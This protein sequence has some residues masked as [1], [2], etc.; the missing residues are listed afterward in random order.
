MDNL[1]KSTFSLDDEEIVEEEVIDRDEEYDE[2]YDDEYDDE[3]YDDGEYDDE[4]YDDDEYADEEEYDDGYNDDYYDDR[5]NKVLDEIAELKRGMVP[6]TV[7]QQQPQQMPPPPPP[8]MPPQ[9]IY[10]PSV[11]SAGSE[12]VM[13][14]EISRLRDE[15][16]KN[17]SSLEMQKE[18]T[19]IKED[20]ARDQRFAEAQYNAEIQRLQGK[21]DELL[22]NADGPQSDSSVYDD[23][24]HL[25]GEKSLNL[26]KLLS[27][28]EV[29]LR[30]MRDSDA[31]IQSEIAQL[32]KQL[33]EIPSLKELNGAVSAVKKALSNAEGVDS[34]AMSKLAAD[35][36]ALKTTLDE[37]GGVA[38]SAAPAITTVVST[39][40][41][42][43][44]STS[45]LLRQ[46]YEIKNALGAS[47]EEAVKRTQVL[48]DLAGEYKKISLDV[49]SQTVQYK[50]KLSAAYGFAKKLAACGE[51]DAV[52][53]IVA[54][55]TI[56][57]KLG[58]QSLNR[59]TF[60]DVAAFCSEN[61][62]MS[63]TSAI[64]DSA[65]KYFGICE[66]LAKTPVSGYGEYIAD[67]VAQ[68]N[69]LEDN[70]RKAENSEIVSQIVG[71]VSAEKPDEAEVRKLLASLTELKVSDIIELPQVELPNDYTP[72]HASDADSIIAR[73]E[74]IHSAVLDS[75]SLAAANEQE[76]ES[77]DEP[78]E[79]AAEEQA[80]AEEPV[81]DN[82]LAQAIEELKAQLAEATSSS[83]MSAAIEEIRK[84]YIDVSEKLVDIS[85]DLKRANSTVVTTEEGSTVVSKSNGMTDEEINE[86]LDNLKYIRSK[87]DEYDEFIRHIDELKSD[88]EKHSTDITDAVAEQY[89]KIVNELSTQFDKLYDDISNVVLESESSI[90]G[91]IGDGLATAEALDAAKSDILADTHSI[92]DVLANTQPIADI[93]AN[94]QSIADVLSDTQ[95]ILSETQSIKDTLL[96]MTDSVSAG[97]SGGDN[98]EAVKAD[99]LAE[100]QSIKDTLVG[101]SDSVYALP[102]TENLEA[103][104]EE[105]LADTQSIKDTLVGISDSIF[106]LPL[107]ENLEATKADLLVETQSIKDTLF[108]LS[109]QLT[110]LQNM[111]VADAVEQ[112]RADVS[113][114]VEVTAMNDENATID[115][116]KLLDDIAFLRE[117]AEL[118][119]AS[120][121][122][123]PDGATAVQD[124]DKLVGYLD[125]IA[126]RVAQLNAIADDASA[127]RENVAA[128]GDNLAAVSDSVALATDTVAA[129]NDSIAAV[130]NGVNSANDGIVALTDTVN[131]VNDS[132]AALTDTFNAGQDNLAAVVDSVN[133]ASDGIAAIGDT[134]NAVNDSVAV[135]TDTFNAD[136]DNLVAVVNTVNAA[137]DGIAALTDTVNSEHDILAVIESTVNAANDGIVSLNGTVAATSDA[138][139]ALGEDAVAARDAAS[140]ALDALAPISEQLSAILDRLDSAPVAYDDGEEVHADE[141]YDTAAAPI[142]DDELAELKES[143]NAILDTLPLFPQADDIVAARDN[144]FSILDTLVAMPQADDVVTT[145]DNVAAI[146]DAVNTLTDSVASALASQGGSSLEGGVAALR[147]TV[148]SVNENI[149]FIRQKLDEAQPEEQ[150]EDIASIMQDLGL[151]LD[152]IEEYENTVAANKQEIID[153]VTG[154]REEI[155]I[156]S[157]DETMSAA[158]IDD[159]TRDALVG[160]IADIRERLGNIETVAQGLSEFNNAIDGINSQLADIQS[161]IA[162]GTAARE[163]VGQADQNMQTIFDELAEIKDKLSVQSEFDTV[164]EI[165]S[166]RED[167]KASRIVDQDEVTSELEAIKNELAFISSGNIVDEIRA[168]R[169]DITGLPS[170]ENG[171][172]PTDGEVNLVLNEIVSL[173][174][175]LFA[176]KDEVLNA[177][178]ALGGNTVEDDMP[179]QVVDSNEDITTILDELT[180]LRADQSVLGENLDEL[181][182]IVSRRTTLA[183]AET[184]ADGESQVAVGELNVVLDEIINLKNDVDRIAESVDNDKFAVMSEQVDEIRAIID[185]LRAG[186]TVVAQAEEVVAPAAVDLAPVMEQLESVNAALDELRMNGV[187]VQ[188]EQPSEPVAVDLAPVMEQLESVN[189]ALD[190]LLLNRDASGVTE[191]GGV[192]QTFA[193]M[194]ES[195]RAEIEEI[196]S[197]I[198]DISVP[199]DYAAELSEL[200]AEIDVLRAENEALKVESTDAVSAQIEELKD[201]LRGALAGERPVAES[202]NGSYAALIDEIRDL[203]DQ[204]AVEQF[205]PTVALEEGDIQAIRDAVASSITVP[206]SEGGLGS[207]LAE[208]RDEIAQ[209]RSL[210]TV[211]ADNSGSFAEVAALRDEL[212]EL[213]SL[214]TSQDNLYGVAEDVTKI[215]ADVQTLRDE[216]DLGVMSEILALRD[217]FQALREEIEDVK[218]IAGET[219]KESDDTLMSEVQS[220]RDQLFAISMANVND[221]TS[222]ESNYESYNNIILDELAAIRDQVSVAGSTSD[223]ASNDIAAMMD[224]LESL[225]EAVESRDE[226]L[227]S[228]VERV[229]RASTSG[230]NDKIMQELAS[231]RTDLANQRDADMA[232]LNFMS[233]MAHLL[234]RQNQYLTENENSGTKISDEIESLKAELAASDAVAEEVAKL[235]EFMTR[236]GAAY[237][238]DTI[239]NE[240]AELREELSSEKP[241]RA[242]DI[243]LDEIARLRGEIIALA[244]REQARDAVSEGDND[245]SDS[246]T[247]LKNEL[248][249]IADIVEPDEKASAPAEKKPA[250][251]RGRK[252]GTKSSGK[253]STSGKKS[254]SSGAKRGRKPK[255]A[256][257]PAPTATDKSKSDIESVIDSALLGMSDD[258]DDM[259]LNINDIAT[260]DAMDIADKLAKQVA[261]KLVMEQLVEQ[262]GD[263]GVSE[264]R[265]DE[266]LRDILP[267]EFTTIAETEASDKVRRLA[268]SLVLDK[269]RARLNGK[270]SDD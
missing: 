185:E 176:F 43:D 114:L 183:A 26:D 4:E 101:I 224:E 67:L 75:A 2:E 134:V 79:E 142:T 201:M 220:L 193:D 230:A 188:T 233:E 108:V 80:Q 54:T 227:D 163:N 91:K 221:P 266:I 190:G 59:T 166:L 219:D 180:A 206:E 18:I 5:L 216:P 124:T 51:Q 155:H 194:F 32:K 81:E 129:M 150:V 48:S 87:L 100:T 199:T 89:G 202:D 110:E 211:S 225:R 253:S 161:A 192:P 28:N 254:T 152:K 29:I 50:D 105:V 187:S 197:D 232:T 112:V 14:N 215:R 261:N 269:L 138:V 85:R 93:L 12:V 228:M 104:K 47:T 256:S 57:A 120:D 210:T 205:K 30:S 38:V 147:E 229:A 71:A 149:L 72:A 235:R 69:I 226:M 237:D 131:A 143:L 177:T 165:L 191:D 55:N 174:D 136:H 25:E 217:E 95:S 128:L 156:N 132:V 121:D 255:N 137:S 181:K 70:A 42:G 231:L 238:N 195:L 270:K 222:G 33:D 158:G 9:Y 167:I 207:E 106:A 212:A 264:E 164:E 98:I 130:N 115:R 35:V 68:L 153:A 242:N 8:I 244:E 118:A 213:K 44:V 240:L 119:I 247:D 151:V 62:I 65:D 246:L 234:E 265:V 61:G 135:L 56:L 260:G 218:R 76:R 257:N 84:N 175:E 133:A 37:K 250:A 86:T 15:L 20:M 209:L 53:F 184:E 204:I 63:I 83:D 236:S 126:A 186:T 19:R 168:L 148:D 208:I 103:V 99:I 252:P 241:S 64:R 10:H 267:H 263:G 262:L 21:I 24:T 146:L 251:K 243:I 11:P 34:E 144:T 172:A 198:A 77:A 171:A 245:L 249:R 58:G 97:S 248:T 39:G 268:N 60:A 41:S 66:K 145:R 223:L 189:A 107:N 178:A 31:R 157:L 45:E 203:K 113:N 117:Q 27:I 36:A 40:N 123:I 49:Q 74:A 78:V 122:E 73:L 52:D 162:T 3:G 141:E 88:I 139:A 46:L 90:L 16:A 17:Q 239:L 179:Q 109:D 6:A 214:I 82:H 200:R 154:I 13:Y 116:Q 196:K 170:G 7:Q 258:D 173:R 22:K 182:D 169:E 125:D 94:T 102:L 259:K 92:K 159:E 140:A 23:Q 96:N 160:E 1:D 111:S 127:T